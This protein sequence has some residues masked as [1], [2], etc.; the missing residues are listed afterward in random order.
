MQGQETNLISV[1]FKNAKETLTI[2]F[3]RDIIDD[4][5]F[6]VRIF[7]CGIIIGHE[8]ALKRREV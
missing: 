8:I 6:G 7:D 1:R 3:G 5:L 2:Q 4:A